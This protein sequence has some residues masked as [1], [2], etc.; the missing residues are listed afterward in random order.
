MRPLS[1][2]VR[3]RFALRGLPVPEVPT[4]VH[5]QIEL[6]DVKGVM[7]SFLILPGQHHMI[8]L[9]G[10]RDAFGRMERVVLPVTVVAR[11]V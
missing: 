8:T 2:S 7:Q 1:R 10:Y 3:H 9:E 11:V 5:V 6:R 4:A